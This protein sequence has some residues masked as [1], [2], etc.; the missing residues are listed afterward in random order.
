MKKILLIIVTTAMLSS[1]VSAQVFKVGDTRTNLTIGVGALSADGKSDATFDQHFT[2]EWGMISMA[3]KFTVGIGFAINNNFRNIGKSAIIGN[4]NYT[5]SYL[6]SHR[7]SG[8]GVSNITTKTNAVRRKGTGTM[9]CDMA[10]DDA[11]AL[12]IATLHYSPINKL[13]LYGIIGAGVGIMTYPVRN[14][15]KTEGFSEYSSNG[16]EIGDRYGKGIYLKTY[17]YYYNDLDHVEWTKHKPQVVPALALYVGGTY[18][19]TEHWGVDLQ[20]G[21]LSANIKVKEN[22]Y[23]SSFGTFAMGASY[24]F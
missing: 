23:P 10:I 13:D 16:T 22:G 9:A 11:D 21:L 2:M 17:P 14:F 20:I 7:Y 3:E 1:A 18:Y 5:Y 12:F 24:K 19:L 4:Y 8:S 15:G 6:S